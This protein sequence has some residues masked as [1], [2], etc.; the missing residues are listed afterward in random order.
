MLFA[1]AKSF[2]STYDFVVIGGGVVGMSVADNLA[3]KQPDSTILVLDKENSTGQH[4]SGRNS[5]VLHAGLYYGSDSL[6]ARFCSE[7]NAWI[8]TFCHDH[9]IPVHECG[10]L[11]VLTS[12]TNECHM[13]TIWNRSRSLK[14]PI[15]RVSPEDAVRLEP[16]TSPVFDSLW[17]PTTAVASPTKFFGVF[18]KFVRRHRNITVQCRSAWKETRSG[19]HNR[20]YI[21]TDEEEAIKAGHIINCSGA[22]A[23]TIAKSFGFARD[24]ICTPFAGYYMY[25]EG[26]FPT[27]LIYPVPDLRKP[28]LGVHFTHSPDGLVKIG[29]TAVPVLRRGHGDKDGASA[30]ESAVGLSKWTMHNPSLA[31]ASALELRKAIPWFLWKD[32][33]K[34]VPS[35]KFNQVKKWAP[36]GYRAQLV[37]RKTGDLMIDFAI[38]GD[39]KSTHVLNVVSPG[40]TCSRPFSEHIVET[41]LS[42]LK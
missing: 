35:L 29:P 40:W 25:V 28:F 9:H 1:Q 32:A 17:S 19:E 33:Q 4:A 6:K 18:D 31:V 3:S 21:V 24:I 37:N 22:W 10:K 39:R 2:S 12:K 23:D 14:I 7:G 5:G 16:L 8:K 26:V 41:V 42:K 30:L 34:L 11:M 15:E 20:P 27:R 36:A 38:E 13:E